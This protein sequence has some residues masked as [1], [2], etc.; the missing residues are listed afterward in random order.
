MPVAFHLLSF[1]QQAEGRNDE[2]RIHA[3]NAEHGRED[4][5]DKSVAESRQ[6]SGATRHQCRGSWAGTSSIRVERWRGAVEV[7]TA[8]ELRALVRILSPGYLERHM[9]LQL[10]A[11]CIKPWTSGVWADHSGEKVSLIRNV[12]IHKSRPITKVNRASTMAR[13]MA[14]FSQ[15]RLLVA[16]AG[17]VAAKATNVKI[18]LPIPAVRKRA[19]VS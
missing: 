2:Y 19:N 12:K 11:S 18:P 14:T 6:G 17:R 9:G 10:T 4:V 1:L 5:V 3:D 15:L 16:K 13:Q 8:V 7:T